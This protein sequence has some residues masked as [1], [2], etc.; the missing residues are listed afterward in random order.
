MTAL[1]RAMARA[2]LRH[3]EPED[4][5]EVRPYADDD[6]AR[7]IDWVA[8]ARTGT[9][10]TRAQGR[11]A[12]LTLLSFVD[13]SGSMRIGRRRPILSAACDARGLWESVAM[14]N[15]RV[16]RLQ[17]LEDALHIPA[18]G[19]LLA[20]GD[21]WEPYGDD[22]ILYRLGKRHDCTALVARDPWARAVPL[23]GFAI[24]ADPQT[25]ERKRVFIGERNRHAYVRAVHRHEVNLLRRLHRLRWRAAL[26]EEA[27]GP[28]AL[29][30]AFELA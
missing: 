29:L 18:N 25:A 6:D 16:L 4:A 14:S 23:R 26:M 17:R 27:D 12:A 7:R 2:R 15:D 9:M 8:T 11:D 13:A 24:L 5:F 1:R 28:G 20:A 19:C 10:Q 30:R 21:F 3:G 22:E